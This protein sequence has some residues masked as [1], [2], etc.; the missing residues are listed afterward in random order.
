MHGFWWAPNNRE[1][2][3]EMI[4]LAQSIAEPLQSHRTDRD[5]FADMRNMTDPICRELGVNETSCV[6]QQVMCD[7]AGHAKVFVV[8]I[9]SAF[10]TSTPWI[11]AGNAQAVRSL[12]PRS[13]Y[14]AKPK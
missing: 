7:T 13:Q 14:G 11:G 5:P 9:R 3:A 6:I 12:Y 1:P 8:L 2:F 10:S 4:N